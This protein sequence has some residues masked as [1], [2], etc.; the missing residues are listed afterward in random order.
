MS[1]QD[2]SL[3]E[4]RTMANYL[5]DG[6]PMVAHLMQQIRQFKRGNEVLL[7]LCKNKIRG[8][9]LVEFFHNEQDNDES[10]GVLRGVQTAMN[11]INND[12]NALTVKDLK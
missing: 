2:I 9:G 4:L 5:Y 3:H 1:D 8:R 7:W 10:A 11:Y 6:E 12:K